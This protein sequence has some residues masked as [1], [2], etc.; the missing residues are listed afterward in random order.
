MAEARDLIPSHLTVPVIEKTLDGASSAEVLKV[1][2]LGKV[3]VIS[4]STFGW[5]A[6]YLAGFEHNDVR[7]YYPEPWFKEIPQPEGLFPSNWRSKPALFE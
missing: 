4:N 6:A 5:W 7:T 3:F 1:M 2:S